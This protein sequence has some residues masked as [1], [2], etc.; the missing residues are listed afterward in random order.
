M[1]VCA[2]SLSQKDK[3]GFH[4]MY[5]KELSQDRAHFNCIGVGGAWL[6][7]EEEEWVWQCGTGA[8]AVNL[9]DPR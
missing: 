6:G 4:Q 7:Q 1:H 3:C 2:A 8:R 9:S 5:F